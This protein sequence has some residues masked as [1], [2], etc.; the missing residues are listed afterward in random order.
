MQL[1]HYSGVRPGNS[2]VVQWVELGTFT[3]RALDQP[4][5]GEQ[6]DQTTIT[7]DTGRS[8]HLACLIKRTFKKKTDSQTGNKLMVTK[9]DG[10]RQIR[11]F[12]LIYIHYYT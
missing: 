8:T 9:G 12:R 5:G 11:S 6:R 7:Q 3:V 10:R 4:L 1:N 2:L